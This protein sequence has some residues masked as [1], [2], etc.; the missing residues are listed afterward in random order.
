MEVVATCA[1]ELGKARIPQ[2][3]VQPV[4][5]L[6]GAQPMSTTR[7]RKKGTWAYTE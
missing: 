4:P 6:S 3:P 2:V 5:V 1:D 7:G